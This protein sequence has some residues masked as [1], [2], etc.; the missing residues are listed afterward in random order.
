MKHRLF[1]RRTVILLAL[2]LVFSAFS[3]FGAAAE[4]AFGI[5]PAPEDTL[6]IAPAPE[7][8]SPVVCRYTI[9]TEG[10]L[11]KAGDEMTVTLSATGTT[12]FLFFVPTV[13][14]GTEITDIEFLDENSYCC[15]SSYG[16]D[17]PAGIA[18]GYEQLTVLEN[19]PVASYVL[20]A[21]EDLTGELT[22]GGKSFEL[23][24]ELGYAATDVT[25]VIDG[26]ETETVNLPEDLDE[27]LADA[28]ITEEKI[29]DVFTGLFFDSYDDYD[30]DDLDIYD[31]MDVEL[32]FTDVSEDDYFF[33]PVTFAYG[34]GITSGV[35]DTLF[36][37]N[38]TCTRAQ[39]VTFLWRLWGTP[40]IEGVENPFVDVSSDAYYY[41]AVLWA[42]DY[43]LTTGTDATHFSPDATVTRE[44][45]V[46]FLYRL[47]G[48]NP[49]IKLA[50]D[51]VS[52]DS[53]SYDAIA[54]ALYNG[55]TNG[56]D[57]SHFSPAAPCTR[58]QIVT[59]IYRTVLE[60]IEVDYDS[61]TYDDGTTEYASL[62]E[63]NAAFGCELVHPGV[64][65][66]TDEQFI[67]AEELFRSAVYSYTVAGKQN[68]QIFIPYDSLNEVVEGFLG[69]AS[70]EFGIDG[71]DA[72]AA[73]LEEI[74]NSD[75]AFVVTVGTLR[76]SCWYAENG[77]YGLG[78]LEIG[79]D[80]EPIGFAD[81]DFLAAAT[82]E[83]SGREVKNISMDL[84]VTAAEDEAED[85]EEIEETEE[86][87][88]ILAVI[89]TDAFADQ[90]PTGKIAAAI[91]L[92][93]N[94]DLSI[95]LNVIGAN[96]EG[97]NGNYTY[98]DGQHI[99]VTTPSLFGE[100][101][102]LSV[103]TLDGTESGS[104]TVTEDGAEWMNGDSEAVALDVFD[105]FGT[106]IGAG[107]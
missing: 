29:D 14:A 7:S 25:R 50:F 26:T 87:M 101:G 86:T 61:F 32:P 55:V 19:V 21:N 95:V 46:T 81:A 13:P 104:I 89:T 96:L 51:D 77:L 66:V 16:G 63:L 11:E 33:K 67:G 22:L 31:P 49:G 105:L 20:T 65:G 71:N 103:V 1:S 64:M 78:S 35:T 91:S 6:V 10:A 42:V 34:S 37:P 97:E 30:Y 48:Y 70:A 83:I 40:E 102:E 84:Y 23:D 17:E 92:T 28:G 52:K 45:A 93:I 4:D 74:K 36:A 82:A 43:G 94:D 73:A 100:E 8:L 27:A 80:G 107:F 76:A 54:W 2:A 41:N 9:G 15:S 56:T 60:P 24:A 59:F 106:L 3:A 53:Y 58:A 47:Y 18:I 62:E 12:G 75:Q 85:V 88:T 69:Q 5:A 39:V 68:Y 98:T 99:V 57:A 44:Q 79:E 72:F 90:I 38:A